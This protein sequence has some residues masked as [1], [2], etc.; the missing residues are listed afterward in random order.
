MATDA[1]RREGTEVRSQRTEDGRQN[2]GKKMNIEQ[3]TPPKRLRRPGRTS[4][5]QHRMKN[6]KNE[7]GIRGLFSHR[8]TQTGRDRGQRSE[9]RGQRANL[10]IR[11]LIGHRRT[12][13][14]RDRGQKS[15]DRGRKTEWREKDEHRTA[16]S[17]EAAAKAGSN[18]EHPTSN[19]KQKK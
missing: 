4:N 15:E 3:H 18:I 6:K 1:H 2:G 16:Y 14:G 13:T 17:A 7:R 12:Q 19:E 8:R 10:G 11:G 5:I 9:V